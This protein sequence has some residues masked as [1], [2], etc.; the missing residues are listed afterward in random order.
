MMKNIWGEG[1]RGGGLKAFPSA[2]EKKL[3]KLRGEKWK[4]PH[5]REGKLIHAECHDLI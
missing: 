1:G 2:R 5:Q 4:P 3:V